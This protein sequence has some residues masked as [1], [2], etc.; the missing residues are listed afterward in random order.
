MRIIGK[1]HH[2]LIINDL[3]FYLIKFSFLLDFHKK[4]YFFGYFNYKLFI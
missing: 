2:Q 1:I 3:M 4:N